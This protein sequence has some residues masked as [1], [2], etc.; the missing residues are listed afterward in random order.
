M[1]VQHHPDTSPSPRPQRPGDLMSI[2]QIPATPTSSP[3]PTPGPSDR[4]SEGW[5]RL[6]P[7]V[8]Q[9]P[10]VNPRDLTNLDSPTPPNDPTPPA[11]PDQL[12]LP[13]LVVATGKGSAAGPTPVPS[14]P[15]AR[16][17]GDKRS[18]A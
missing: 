5:L 6:V 17:F 3:A 16:P 9:Q 2:P 7:A 15:Q 14:H 4:G 8:R 12:A 1:T 18:A 10:A 11:T 13:R